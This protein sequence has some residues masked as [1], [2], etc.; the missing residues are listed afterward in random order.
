MVEFVENLFEF[1]LENRPAGS[2]GTWSS[3]GFPP[4][5]WIIDDLAEHGITLTENHIIKIVKTPAG[6]NI[7]IGGG[8]KVNVWTELYDGLPDEGGKLVVTIGWTRISKGI[9]KEVR[10]GDTIVWGKNTAALETAQCMGVFLDID[11]ALAAFQVDKAKGR[12][13]WIEK[14]NDVLS[15]P[16]DWDSKGVSLLKKKM[17]KMPDNNYLEML[18]L[19]KGVRNFVDQYGQNLGGSYHIIHGKINKYYDAEEE[20]FKLDKK[21]KANTADF[22]LTNTFPEEVIDAVYNQVIKYDKGKGYCYTNDGRKIK[23]YQISLKM[24]HGQLGKVTQAMRDRYNLSDS[25]EFYLSIVSDYLVNHGYELNEGVLSWAMDKVS[26]GLLVMKSISIEWFEKIAG[27]VNKLKDWAKGLSSSFNSKMPSGSPN[28]F[29]INLMQEVLREDGRLGQGEL[30][31]EARVDLSTKG[32]TELL[33]TTN[34]AGAQKIVKETNDGIKQISKWFASDNLMAYAE[35]G[36]VNV[37]NYIQKGEK[38][39]WKYGEII[40]IFANATAVDAFSNMLKEKK[41]NINDIVEEQIDLAKEIYFG[42]TQLPLFRVY[43]AKS[44]K[45]TNTVEDLGTAK[46]WTKGKLSNLTG[47]T[48]GNWPV[49]GFSSTLQQDMYYNISAGIIAGTDKKGAEPEYVN[50]AM[51]TNRSDAYS[52]VVEGSST[53]TFAQ[54]KTKFGF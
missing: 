19:A 25:S 13:D 54:F 14:I 21:L 47:D 11:A 37:G 43:G 22:I 18:L 32:I 29:Q 30:L 49:I 33:K 26:Q 41:S 12:T 42:K 17:P 50:L 35:K 4:K 9:F 1:N 36:V 28:S 44:D 16:Y 27:Y 53:L 7:T 20:N 8:D 5:K 10:S 40:K 2:L 46:D 15:K 52:F 3:N 39:S 24:A 48:L 34:Q 51:R 31:T 45:D 23:Y 6:K 38:N